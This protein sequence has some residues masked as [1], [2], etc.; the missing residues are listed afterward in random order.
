MD[1]ITVNVLTTYDSPNSLALLY[2]ILINK[3]LLRKRGVEFCF[4]DRIE[5][6]L[7]KG[8]TIFMNSKFFKAWYAEKEKEVYSILEN[9]KKKMRKVIW[10]DASDSTGTTQFNVMPFVD[11][12]YKGHV[13]KDKTLYCKPFYGYRIFTDYY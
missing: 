13:L 9:A 3:T 4:F 2:P 8:D 11:G 5:R 12:Y 6:G 1:K 7:Y 10:F